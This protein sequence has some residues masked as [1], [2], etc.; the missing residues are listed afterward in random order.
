MTKTGRK[1]LAALK[2][3]VS[4]LGTSRTLIIDSPASAMERFQR[5]DFYLGTGTVNPGKP[6]ERYSAGA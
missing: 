4:Q 5:R 3:P 2:P 6:P 1:L